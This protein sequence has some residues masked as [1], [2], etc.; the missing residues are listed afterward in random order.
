ML[1]TSMAPQDT[2]EASPEAVLL[3]HDASD[4]RTLRGVTAA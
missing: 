2:L 3:G 4:I 1:C